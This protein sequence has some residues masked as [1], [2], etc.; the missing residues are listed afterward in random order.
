MR[1]YSTKDYHQGIYYN[2]SHAFGY[3]ALFYIFIG[4]RGCGKT[5][6]AL[7]YCLKKFF[8]KGKRFLWLRLKE[9]S[10]KALLAN[11]AKDFID[12]ALLEKYGITGLRTEGNVVFVSTVPEPSKKSDYKEMCKIMALSTFYIMKGVALNKKSQIDVLQK[13]IEKNVLKGVKKYSTIVL[14]EMNQER[15]EKKTFD[16]SYSF[17]N[18]LE[19]T[20]RTDLDRRIILCGNTLEEGSDILSNCF[21]FIPNELGTYDIKRKNCVID[22]IDD[23]EKYKAERKNSIAGILA[24]NESTFTN[25]IASDLDLV[26]KGKAPS[27]PSYIIRF[28]TGKDFVVCSGVITKQKVSKYAN[29]RIV[30]MRPYLVGVPY[31]KELAAE[32]LVKA[33]TMLFKFDMLKTLKQFYSEIK[34]LKQ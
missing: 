26:I 9:P 24:P 2:P 29:I 7:N 3:N 15:S 28:D 11:N 14:D 33:Q 5:V 19:T 30:A 12:S 16:I 22:Y 20:C 27:N 34:L 17:V 18:A 13:E 10:V 31:Y 32:V 4:G 23:S 8:K 25:K 21:D 6:S 1:K